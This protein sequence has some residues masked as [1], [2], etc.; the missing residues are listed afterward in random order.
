MRREIMHLPERVLDVLRAERIAHVYYAEEC[1]GLS[2]DRSLE[3]MQERFHRLVVPEQKC[4]VEHFFE[5]EPLLRA[6]LIKSADAIRSGRVKVF[7]AEYEVGRKPN[8]H[9]EIDSEFTWPCVHHTKIDFWR[10]AGSA[11]IRWVWELNAF[12]QTVSLG[13]AYWLTSNEDYTRVFMSQVN[14]WIEKNP[15]YYGP[16]WKCPMMV[17]I[18]AVNL[19]W[20]FAF[21][22]D[23]NLVDRRFRSLFLNLMRLHGKFI[24]RHLENKSLIRGN[25]YL[26]NLIGLIYISCLCP[27]LKDSEM[28][29][30]FGSRELEI[31]IQS[32]VHKDGVN[33]EASLPYHG[34]VTEMLLH[35]VVVA[36]RVGS[37]DLAK[38]G[39]DLE[40]PKLQRSPNVISQAIS[41]TLER[42]VEFTLYYSKPDG[43]TPQIG[44]ND[45]SRLI[46]LGTN[47]GENDHRHILACA[48]EIF[49]RDDFRRA[50]A[51][52]REEAIWLLQAEPKG[53]VSDL[54]I[55]EIGSRWFSES[56][57]CVMRSKQDYN[58]IRCGGIGTAGKGTHTHND[59]LSFELCL[60]GVTYLVDPGTFTYLG[61]PRWRQIFR[62][63]SY[64]NTLQIDG[65]EQHEFVEDDL[66]RLQPATEA[67]MLSWSS[68]S[69]EDHFCGEIRY[70]GANAILHRREFR[71]FKEQRQMI[72]SDFVS[73][74][75]VHCL[76]WRLHVAPGIPAVLC[77]GGILLGGPGSDE[78]VFLSGD[79]MAVGNLSVMDYYYSPSYGRRIRSQV[80]EIGMQGRL[81]IRRD[82]MVRIAQS[83]TFLSA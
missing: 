12:R 44:D 41:D 52:C 22:V 11:D 81:P 32:Q 33:F 57:I 43:L 34:L 47:Q 1:G 17:A 36:A 45:S 38:K 73:G 46:V 71:F 37:P 54:R 70:P 31:E 50:G 30:N 9:H 51:S 19:A 61:K 4:V 3:I 55:P 56:G 64:H 18:R 74:H 68:T 53:L 28:W 59:N 65:R 23:S 13:K 35:A 16:S 20:S 21:F 29:F 6:E 83:H 63:T 79:I 8:W 66:F 75:D 24:F 60:G 58:I 7:R 14:D 82:L 80:I 25:H 26:A 78:R 10:L 42:M 40:R 48:G 15:L 62:S 5:N 27:M 76:T 77:A 39:G 49:D 67:R 2:T 72:V 69:R